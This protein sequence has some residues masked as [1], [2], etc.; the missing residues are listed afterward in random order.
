RLM[1]ANFDKRR[2][3]CAI[4]E[5]NLRLVETARQV[6]ASAKFTG[7]GGAIIGTYPDERTY[8]RLT[9]VFAAQQVCV[10]KPDIL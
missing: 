7:S 9:E 3:I 4:G 10:F 5:G 6:G 8:T 2:E 1:N